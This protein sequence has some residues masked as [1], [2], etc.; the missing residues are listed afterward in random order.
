LAYR[1]HPGCAQAL[2]EV[3]AGIEEEGVH[4]RAVERE[5]RDAV[6]LAQ[7]AATQSQRRRPGRVAVVYPRP[8]PP[9]GRPLER[10]GTG[11]DGPGCRRHIGHNAARLVKVMPLQGYGDGQERTLSSEAR[12]GRGSA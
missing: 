3:C 8:R 1:P 5:S 9:G 2:H 11:S 7:H 12:S 6:A 10:L 4:F